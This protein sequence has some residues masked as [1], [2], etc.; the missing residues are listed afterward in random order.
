MMYAIR[1]LHD[2]NLVHG[3]V[4]TRKLL[5]SDEGVCKLSYIPR[6]AIKLCPQPCT[7]SEDIFDCGAVLLEMCTGEPVAHGA[8]VQACLG[9]VQSPRLREVASKCLSRIPDDRPSARA[10]IDML[11]LC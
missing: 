7:Q 5:L 10:V 11:K 1:Y 9:A 8:D 6:E 3:A 4:T 2:R